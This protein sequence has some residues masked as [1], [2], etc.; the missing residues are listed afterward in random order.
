MVLVNRQKWQ[1]CFP[2]STKSKIGFYYMNFNFG[3]ICDEKEIADRNSC[4]KV[5]MVT[6]GTK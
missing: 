5:V 4:T 2:K 1:S 3:F 6:F